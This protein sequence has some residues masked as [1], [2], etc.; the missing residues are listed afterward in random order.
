[1]KFCFF[2]ND[3]ATVKLNGKWGL[4]NKNGDFIISPIYDYI[5]H[6][7]ENFITIQIGNKYGF[8]DKN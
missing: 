1:M 3:I 8:A 7:N 2:Y 4:I 6:L 5:S